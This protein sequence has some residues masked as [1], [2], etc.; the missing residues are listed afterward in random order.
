VIVV[1]GLSHRTASIDVRERLAISADEIP[2]LLKGLVSLPSLGEALVV[3]T[4]N[5]VEFVV[6]GADGAR[7]DLSGIARA[8]TDAILA[9]APG[10]SGHLYQH[11][12][13]DAVRHLFRVAASLDSLVVGEPQI[14]GQVKQSYDLAREVGTAGSVLNRVVPRAL[15][16]AKRVRSQ[17]TIGSG[18]VSVPSVAVDLA[19][20]IFGDLSHRTAALVGS[21]DM[22]ETVARLLRQAG[23][24]LVVVG[25]NPARV[26]EIAATMQG[27]PRTFE[28]LD[29]TL[30]EADVVVTTT[31]AP[32]FVVEHDRVR[33]GRKARKG[34]SL[35]FIDLAVPRDVDPRVITIDGVFLYN[36]DDLSKV[37]SESLE[38]RRREADRAE[39]IVAEEAANYE[40]WADSE[41]VTPTVLALRERVRGV[42]EAELER[43]LAGKLRHLSAEDRQALLV[44]NEASVNKLLHE[45]T[46]RLRRMASD[47]GLRADLDAAIS[48]LV[49]MFDLETLAESVR[50]GDPASLAA[51]DALD[52]ESDPGASPEPPASG[53]NPADEP[54]GKR[55]VHRLGS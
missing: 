13:L 49:D 2:S 18:Q 3:S 43:S 27:E 17:T 7:A 16:S 12:G 37:V 51:A 23:A 15:R 30:E 50:P 11:V 44:M 25:R 28:D 26:G 22:G 35:F 40:R 19:R 29:W 55:R 31:S 53:P 4:C 9:R 38:S 48:V 5:R 10:V 36:V 47:P 41:Q 1:I 20:Q 32:G 39:Q 52:I 8:A 46:Q 6:A 24:K 45:T 33:R 34:R 21:G 54:D 42:L 14:L